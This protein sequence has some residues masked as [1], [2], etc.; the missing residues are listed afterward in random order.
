MSSVKTDHSYAIEEL[1]ESKQLGQELVIHQE[2]THIKDDGNEVLPSFWQV[3]TTRNKKR[4]NATSMR[5]CY[6]KKAKQG[7][8][9]EPTLK[10]ENRFDPLT[11][12]DPSNQVNN[13]PSENTVKNTDLKPKI[14]LIFN[15]IMLVEC[16]I[17]KQWKIP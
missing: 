15:P 17:P 13:E 14:S 7:S 8:N 11:T 12:V 9:Q 5:I 3:S 16:L 4:N 1:N 10:L 2:S 6:Q